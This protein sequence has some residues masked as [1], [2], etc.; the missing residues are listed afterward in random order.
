MLALLAI[1]FFLSAQLPSGYTAHYPL[2]DDAIEAGG[3][4]SYNGT[5][6]SVAGT[7]NRFG[8]SNAAIQL[9]SGTSY[10]TI[11]VVVKDNFTVGFWIKTNMTANSSSQWYG[12]NSLIDAE[13]CGVTND[14]GI[15][16]INGG[17]I[18][19]GTGNPD[20]TIISP[21]SYND[22]AWHFITATRDKSGTGTMILY[23]DGSQVVSLTSVNT[24]T[25]SAPTF[26]GLGRNDCTGADYT[27]SLDDLIFYPSALS[28]AQVTNLYSYMNTVV[29]AVNW[30]SFSG[31]VSG[32]NINLQWKVPDSKQIDHFE[33]EHSTDGE[34]FSL[35]GTL[36]GSNNPT[37]GNVS[38]AFADGNPAS[39]INYYRIKQVDVDGTYSYSDI[40]H[41]SF[42]NSFSGIRLLSNPVINNMLV[43]ENPNQQMIQAINIIDIAGRILERK[44]FQSQNTSLQINLNNLTPGYYFIRVSTTA[45]TVSIP[46]IK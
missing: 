6:T 29:L 39:G 44:N 34:T 20:K 13:V 22:N 10:G 19:F 5:L 36:P 8:T 11:P 41:F 12:G 24:G 33:I 4:A 30:I 38:F 37:D 35:I 17:K 15:A 16:L 7:T 43:I 23:V 25:L 9:T 14:W 46:F 32:S 28:S 2:N 45:K 21:L 31:E 27:G 3:N 42:Q 26:I 18:A 1:P 40:I